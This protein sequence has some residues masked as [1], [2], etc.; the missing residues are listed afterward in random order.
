MRT[1]TRKKEEKNKNENL[2]YGNESG[3]GDSGDGDFQLDLKDNEPAKAGVIFDKAEWLTTKETAVYLRKFEPNGAPSV[4]AIHKLVA[5]G[6]IRRRKFL[7]R[8]FFRKKE[9]EFLIE[10]SGA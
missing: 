1:E 5:R 2:G 3:I 6:S 8:L 9:L 4:N 10:T 7:G